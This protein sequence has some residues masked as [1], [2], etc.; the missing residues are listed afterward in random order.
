[1]LLFSL[2][3]W[4]LPL[5]VRIIS[6]VFNKL[7]K[8][9]QGLAP[10]SYSDVIVSHPL[11]LSHT[12]PPSCSSQAPSMFKHMDLCT[13]FWNALPL[14]I[15]IVTPSNIWPMSPSVKPSQVPLSKLVL[16]IIIFSLLNLKY[17]FHNLKTKPC[18]FQRLQKMWKS[19]NKTIKKSITI[20]PEIV[21]I[22]LY[23]F[24]VFFFLFL[25]VLFFFTVNCAQNEIINKIYKAY[26]EEQVS[27]PSTVPTQAHHLQQL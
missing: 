14:S 19:T 13:S 12:W 16:S 26:C 20:N 11:H 1:M 22:L 24:L 7:H 9:P 15:H 25:L 27:Y 17:M 18:S 10:S 3:L 23:F 5:V 21:N 4:Q 6:E 8:I 2:K